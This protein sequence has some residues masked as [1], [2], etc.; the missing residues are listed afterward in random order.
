MAN[1]PDKFP[2]TDPINIRNRLHAAS[3]LAKAEAMED[4]IGVIQMEEKAGVARAL[5]DVTNGD[6]EPQSTDRAHRFH[7]RGLHPAT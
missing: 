7:D 1:Y 6:V 4:A 3:Q 5:T 2:A